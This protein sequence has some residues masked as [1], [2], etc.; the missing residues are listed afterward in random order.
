MREP[1]KRFNDI[2]YYSAF[3]GGSLNILSHEPV[4]ELI[5]A[6]DQHIDIERCLLDLSYGVMASQNPVVVYH[7]LK[8]LKN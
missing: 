8:M 5:V 1:V 2:V 7:C 6:A 3:G 4:T